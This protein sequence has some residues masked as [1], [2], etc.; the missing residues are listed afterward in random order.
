ML[1]TVIKGGTNACFSV[2]VWAKLR[3]CVSDSYEQERKMKAVEGM[4]LLLLLKVDNWPICLTEYCPHIVVCCV[5]CGFYC[6]HQTS[7][8]R[9]MLEEW[10]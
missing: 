5:I 4:L 6:Q 2:I 10:V 1:Q 9:T 8:P 3:T 7:D